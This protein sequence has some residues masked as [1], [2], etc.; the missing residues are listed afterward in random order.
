[1]VKKNVAKSRVSRWLSAGA[2]ALSAC[3]IGL[4]PLATAAADNA[5]VNGQGQKL[6]QRH[7]LGCH[8]PEGSEPLQLSR[9]SHQRKTPEG[10][11]MTIAR[12]QL[13]HGLEISD[14]DRRALV[15]HLADTQGLSPDESAPYR[16]VLERRLNH[17]EDKQP[18]LAEMCARCHSEARIGLQRRDQKEWE[19]LVHFHL[20]QWPSIE[21][22]AMGRD[23]DWLGIA[24]NE[25][26]P[27]LGQHYGL[28]SD[29][30]QQWQDKAPA[31]FSGRWRLVGNMP[32]RGAFQGIMTATPD[33]RDEYSLSLKGRFDSGQTLRGQGR[34]VVYSGYE[35]RADFALGEEKF[36]QVLAL[37]E[38]GQSLNG[39]MFLKGQETLGLDLSAVHEGTTQLMA[40]SPSYLQNGEEQVLSLRG[41]Q[42]QGDVRFGKGITLLEE[43]ERSADEIR[44][45]VKAADSA[46][47]VSVA[48]GDSTFAPG[49]TVYQR[50]GRLEVK[51]AYAVARVGEGGSNSRKVN[52]AFEAHAYDPGGDGINGTADDLYIGVLPAR[53]R[54]APF[55]A[56]AVKDNDLAFAGEIDASTG[57]F[58]PGDA[59]PNPAR[60]Y[61]TNNAGRLAV[62]AEVGSQEASLQA[63]AELIVTVQRWNNPP[64]R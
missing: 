3:G 45:R 15:K 37:D 54:L 17:I 22:S 23:R 25:V 12:M 26:V 36:Q 27:Y 38:N 8:V 58:T 35:W 39:R 24:L 46:K 10:W 2:L 34:A 20:G 64:I 52:A 44:V 9:I 60:K 61:G 6:L 42:L 53:W 4:S 13:V 57:V 28:Q 16:Y 1:M 49:L 40:V 19:H 43:V 51:P 55:D 32:G 59:G 63:Q 14:E 56:Q 11:L 47:L 31:D 48:V 7:C 18:E 41:N 29:N 50:I 21:Y 5:V 33:G 62:I 30:W